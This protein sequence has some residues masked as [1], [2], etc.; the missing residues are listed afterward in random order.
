MQT[1]CRFD[2]PVWAGFASEDARRRIAVA[3][4][5]HAQC[6]ADCRSSRMDCD[7]RLLLDAFAACTLEQEVHSQQESQAAG[8]WFRSVC[9]FNQIVQPQIAPGV[10]EAA[11]QR[12]CECTTR[13]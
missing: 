5:S 3:C 10:F 4:H 7:V 1:A 11:N 6:Y 2:G 8:I 9:D 13:G 12:H